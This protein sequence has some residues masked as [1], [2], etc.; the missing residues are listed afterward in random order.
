[1]VI[2]AELIQWK[3]IRSMDKKPC[4]NIIVYAPLRALTQLKDTL[5][6]LDERLVSIQKVSDNA[7]M[8]KVWNDAT[9]AA[10]KY[11]QTIDQS[12]ASYEA[13][14]KLG[15]NQQDATQ[16]SSASMM[17]ATVGEFKDAAEATDYL[18]AI[19]KQ[20]KLEVSDTM[21]VVDALNNL[22][23]KSGAD[24]ISLAQGLSKASSAAAMAKVSFHELS[25]M[26]ATT[27]ETLHISG[28]EAGNFYKTLFTRFLRPDSQETIQGIGVATTKMNGELRSATDVLRDVGEVWGTLDE[29]TQNAV[30]S[31]LGGVYHV[32]K[33]TSLL[34]NQ[35]AVL[36][37]TSSSMDSLG[38]ATTELA[39]FEN[40]LQFKTNQ[41]IATF[42]ELVMTIGENGARDA[43]VAFLE[44][45]TFLV[46]GFNDVTDATNGWN[47]KL[48]ILAAGIY[49]IYKAIKALSV[50]GIALKASFGWIGLGVIAVETLVSAFAGAKNSVEGTAESFQKSANS[51]DVQRK[52]LEQLVAKYDELKPLAEGNKDKQEELQ[53]VLEQIQRIA[54]ALIESTG[55]YGDALDLNRGKVDSYVASLK[56]MTK[57]ELSRA[58][59]ANQ[60]EL[61]NVTSELDQLEGQLDKS[62]KKIKDKFNAMQS[63]WD[64]YK[65]SG[66]SD[67]E[68]EFNNRI[69]KQTKEME[70]AFASGDKQKTVKLQKSLEKQKLEYKNYVSFMKDSTGELKKYSDNVNKAQELKTK[71]DGLEQNK[72][73][74]KDATESLN[75]N[76]KANKENANSLSQ[77]SSEAQKSAEVV[78]EY[79]N[80][81]D[82]TG[83]QVSSLADKLKEAKGDFDAISK[84]IVDAVKAGDIENAQTAMMTD[85]YQTLSD[86]ISPLNDLLEKMAQGKQISAAEAM[87]LMAKE[88][89][90]VGAISVENGQVKINADAVRNLRDT[91]VASYNDMLKSVQQ[92]AINTANATI[93]KLS[94]YKIEI[95][96]IQNLQ[97]AK[98]RLAELDDEMSNKAEQAFKN[99]QM[100]PAAYEE[101]KAYG[102]NTKEARSAIKD[103]VDLSE[104]IDKLSAMATGGLNQVGTSMENLSDSTEKANKESE[105]STYIA[106]EYAL[107]L[108]QINTQLDEQNNLQG[109]LVEGSQAHID[110]MKAEIEL[111]KAKIA[112]MKAQKKATEDQI[113]AGKIQEKGVVTSSGYTPTTTSGRT[114][115]QISNVTGADLNKYL[116]GKLSGFGDVIVSAAK[117]NGIDPAF[118]AAIAMHESGRG[119]SNAIKT[120]NNAFGIMKSSGGL[121]SFASLSENIQYAADMIKRLYTSQGLTTVDT[122]Q[123]KYAPIGVG[124]D[125]NGLNASWVDGVNKFWEQ[126]TGTIVN[127]ASTVASGASQS[128]VDY[129]L[130]N[131]KYKVSST[132]GD[133]AGRNSAHKGL[134]LAAPAGTAI[135]AIQ[136]GKVTVAGYSKTAGNWVIVDHGGGI[137]SKYMHMLKTPNVKA[138]QTVTAG[139]QIGQVGNTGD[140]KGNHLHLQIEQNGQAVDPY[141][142]MKNYGAEFNAANADASKSIAENQQSLDQARLDVLNMQSEINSAEAQLQAMYLEISKA[143]LAPFERQIGYLDNELRKL[144]VD[145]ENIYDK[146]SKDYRNG[147][148]MQADL[149][150]QRL[151]NLAAEVA[152]LQDEI[153]NN[154][155]LTLGQKEE[156]NGVLSDKLATYKELQDTILEINKAILNNR[157]EELIDNINK[158]VE[159]LNRNLSDLEIAFKMIAD[160]NEKGQLMNLE[161]QIRELQ[162][163]YATIKQNI[164]YHSAMQDVVKGDADL[165]QKNTDELL[166]WR[167][168]LLKVEEQIYQLDLTIYNQRVEY[169]LQ[170]IINKTKELERALKK[171][172]SAIAMTDTEDYKAL[173]DLQSQRLIILRQDQVEIQN[174]IDALNKLGATLKENSQ[175]WDENNQKIKDA[176]DRLS[177]NQVEIYNQQQ[178]IKDMYKKIADD[179]IS[180]MKDAIEAKRD[181]ELQAIDDVRAEEEKAYNKR[182]EWYDDELS[183]LDELYNKKMRE[184]DDQKS[185]DDYAKQLAKLQEEQRKIQADYNKLSLDDS[186]WAKKRKEELLKQLGD[187]EEEIN[188]LVTDRNLELRKQSLQ[189]EKDEIQNKLE[190]ERKLEQDAYDEKS[191][192]RDQEIKDI[193]KKYDNLINDE[194]KWSAIRQAILA[195]DVDALTA[196]IDT[197]TKF[198]EENNIKIGESITNNIIDT[199][200]K[201]KEELAS[202]NASYSSVINQ[203]LPTGS[204]SGGGQGTANNTPVPQ[205]DV[206]HIIDATFSGRTLSSSTPEKEALLNTMKTSGISQ[207]DLEL[208]WER[209]Q[210][211]G[212]IYDTSNPNKM[213]IF[214]MMKNILDNKSIYEP[215]D[216]YAQMVQVVPI[217]DVRHVIDA[218]YNGTT[219][220]SPSTEKNHLYSA[221]NEA[222]K[223]VPYN[224]MMHVWDNAQK[225]LGLFS[226]T[227]TKKRLYDMFRA[228]LGSQSI[229]GLESGGFTGAFN[230]GKLAILH[231]KELVLNKVDTKNILSAVD[232]V[233]KF[234]SMLPKLKLPSLPSINV[235]QTPIAGTTTINM[236]INI[237]HIDGG[238]KGANTFFKTIEKGFK[239]RGIKF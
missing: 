177:D 23:N 49:G 187:K 163:Y 12:L 76:T 65:V 58:S 161:S 78:D 13:V 137:I 61:A 160:S 112:I 102:R 113:A 101:M 150:A 5:Y 213:T 225:N 119:T 145:T 138:G 93:K 198:L 6:L 85:A 97:D 212:V 178:A 233:R 1:M 29:Q 144:Q 132:F 64:K 73:A 140:S 235:N 14:A 179:Y 139:Q 230:G 9:D 55:K 46:K 105:L 129:Y 48:P 204:G 180:A 31:Q 52:N 184:I 156:L 115:T 189:D 153:Q 2:Y 131:G 41:M 27:Q 164:K 108:A 148:Q 155:I 82:G 99:G 83:V 196:E 218:A 67:A 51:M 149:H 81:A 190:D 205:Q 70:D 103:V 79:G 142:Y 141:T 186:A 38:S 120:K 172:D 211:G 238:E 201:A 126:F 63:Y 234:Q 188:Q 208:M 40:G 62:D 224:E 16:L 133:T 87:N 223:E 43:I 60:I 109:L 24:T 25:G 100:N 185:Q 56:Q 26:I 114:V 226:S 166:K 72:K 175:A 21:T 158:K 44:S 32:N 90:L 134:D 98:K 68:K 193:N 127:T 28:N 19:M 209:A 42:Q 207:R 75:G 71:K 227:P 239:E 220:N 183:K 135:Q 228:I 173:L 169:V 39:T 77:V 69:K 94:S 10:M 151:M 116:S 4:D 174:E 11:G 89:E 3:S 237:D 86:E 22:S 200:K 217:Q 96:A 176:Q 195:K 20:Y 125:P 219:L 181:A 17:L 167:D 15:Y 146:T 194:R 191:D 203:P 57:E 157:L 34:E 84:A 66:L 152:I 45:V 121:R 130:N 8:T 128:V 171:L 95:E 33:V 47:I 221:L 206:K 168:E 118:L 182:M 199:L 54:P 18:T 216:P 35:D 162:K 210:Q 104:N 91:K 215:A 236:N 74:I 7:D 30:A 80:T 92:E 37:N 53:S 117:A 154:N 110:S 50:A 159:T 106:D 202:L 143:R 59:T 229:T 147:M 222:K 170:K 107:K 192:M 136:S 124:N 111:M 88:E 122:I 197:I 232:M 165:L 214:Q 231:E 123:K 36:K